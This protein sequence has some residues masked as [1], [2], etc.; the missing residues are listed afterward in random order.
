[1]IKFAPQQTADELFKHD[2][3]KEFDGNSIY[4][5]GFKQIFSKKIFILLIYYV[6]HHDLLP[7]I[8]GKPV[9]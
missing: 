1:M 9:N 5:S 2:M 8:S 6:I 7:Q 3:E 4:I